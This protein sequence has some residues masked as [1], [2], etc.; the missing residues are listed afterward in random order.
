MDILSFKIRKFKSDFPRGKGHTN[1]LTEKVSPPLGNLVIFPKINRLCTQEAI[2]FPSGSSESPTPAS[3]EGA[4]CADGTDG[5]T[6]GRM[7]G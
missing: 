2:I 5:W 3:A 1:F 6:D 4:S 7:D